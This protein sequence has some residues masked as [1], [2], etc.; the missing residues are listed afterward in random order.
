M[1]YNLKKIT[2]LILVFA[3]SLII[4]IPA[5][6]AENDMMHANSTLKPAISSNGSFTID[7]KSVLISSNFKVTSTSSTVTIKATTSGSD[8]YYKVYFSGNDGSGGNAR[9]YA[10]GSYQTYTFT[11]LN[12]S[13]TYHLEFVAGGSANIVGSG[14]I[15]NYKAV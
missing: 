10:D 8:K 6:A 1:K 2:S 14:T 13:A 11:G 12:T 5:F 9:Y 7:F 4:S 15:S 3:L